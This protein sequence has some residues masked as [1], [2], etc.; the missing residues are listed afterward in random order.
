M[1]KKSRL[2]QT[3][4]KTITEDPGVRIRLNDAPREKTDSVRAAML[5][6]SLKLF[7]LKWVF[8][9]LKISNDATTAAV[10]RINVMGVSVIRSQYTN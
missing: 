7:G 4:E 1:Q 10:S 6:H 5:N 9:A 8:K 2:S 3:I